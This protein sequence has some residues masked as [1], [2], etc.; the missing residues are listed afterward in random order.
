[1]NFNPITRYVKWN[2]TGANNGSSWTDA[3]N[4]LQSAL[5]AS[6]S[7]DEIWVAAGTY[8]PGV[9]RT[10]TFQLVSGVEVYGGFVGTETARSQRDAAA[11]LT[12][13]SGDIGTP[14]VNTDNSYHVVTG[15]GTDST[16]MLDGFTITGGYADGG[17]SNDSGAGMLNEAGSPTLANVIFSGNS[18]GSGSG[19]FNYSSSP[20]LMNVTF[21]DNVGTDGS[22][23]GAMVNDTNSSPTLTNVTFSG[24]SAILLGGGMLNSYNSNPSLMNVTF[25]GNSANSGGGIYNVSSTPSLINVILWGDTAS[26]GSEIFNDTS[27]PPFPIAWCRGPAAAAPGIPAWAP[28]TAITWM[29][30]RCWTHW[31]NNGGFTQTMALGRLS[32]H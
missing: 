6:S 13:L 31:L 7:G 30:I 28:T 1:M 10:D 32:R 29:P 5:S 26:T 14:S 21:S 2:A 12:V 16:A 4:D 20:S 8:K 9:L 3:Y 25:S 17:S 19:M 11:N 24:N 22:R 23:G 27:T 18:A 15:S